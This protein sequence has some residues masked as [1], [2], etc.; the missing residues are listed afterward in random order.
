VD[1]AKALSLL[2]PAYE[3]ALRLRDIG[4]DDERIAA[5]LELA[6]E[7]VPALLQIGER[8]LAALLIG[9]VPPAGT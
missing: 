9:E 7:A 6:P 1:R 8:K 4:A 2:P 3:A 5:A